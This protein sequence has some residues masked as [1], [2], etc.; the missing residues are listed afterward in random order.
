MNRCQC[1]NCVAMDTG[2]ESVCCKGNP[3]VLEKMD[4]AGTGC[5]TNHA[6]FQSTSLNQIVVEVS[7]YAYIQHALPIDDNEPI[8]K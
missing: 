8:Y 7:L 1:G 3:L 5:F 6:G 2:R 4:A